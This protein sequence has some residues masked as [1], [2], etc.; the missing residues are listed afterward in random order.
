MSFLNAARYCRP[1]ATKRFRM[2]RRVTSSAGSIEEKRVAEVVWA[3]RSA[4]A[5]HS[6]PSGVS[7]MVRARRSQPRLGR[8]AE[9]AEGR[10]H[11]EQPAVDAERDQRV[12]EG[13]GGA[14]MGHAQEEPD[15]GADVGD[16]THGTQLTS[17]L[18]HLRNTRTKNFLFENFLLASFV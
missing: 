14:L 15:L 9:A 1:S 18:S 17:S 11:A 4:A 6:R 16:V 13:A 3:L 5:R 10:E 7:A 12:A 2:S 8:R